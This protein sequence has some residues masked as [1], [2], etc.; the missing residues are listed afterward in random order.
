[1]TFKKDL[2]LQA[3]MLTILKLLIIKSI[4]LCIKLL[5]EETNLSLA[6]SISKLLIVNSSFLFMKE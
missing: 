2:A 1:M 3:S 6:K 5:V 4:I